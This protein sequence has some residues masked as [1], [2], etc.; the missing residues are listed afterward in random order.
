MLWRSSGRNLRYTASPCEEQA[1]SETA[2][3]GAVP[4][5]KS[6]VVHSELG[7]GYADVGY[8]VDAAGTQFI[9]C[10][11]S[12][13]N[14]NNIFVDLF[15]VK[16]GQP[17]P[18]YPAYRIVPVDKLDRAQLFH[19]G[20]D[21]IVTLLTHSIS[22]PS[23]QARPI[24]IEQARLNGIFSVTASYVSEHGGEGVVIIPAEG[25]GDVPVDYA[26]I[27]SDTTEVVTKVVGATIDNSLTHQIIGSAQQSLRQALRDDLDKDAVLKLLT[28]SDDKGKHYQAA[29]FEFTKNAAANPHQNI[30]LQQDEWGQNLYAHLVAA[31]KEGCLQALRT[32]GRAG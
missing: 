21:L 12:V 18:Q 10:S 1:M 29:L 3:Q 30:L 14:N 24:N 32:T 23:G 31:V 11:N 19:S 20:P 16:A 7:G 5:V 2:E 22:T 13:W 25:G 15:V 17:V 28:E 9:A 26:K 8:I 4:E 27:K 6:A